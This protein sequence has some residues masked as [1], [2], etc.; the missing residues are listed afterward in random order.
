MLSTIEK[1]PTPY[2]VNETAAIWKITALWA[3]SE[4]A[5]GGVLHAF[6]V[7]FRG[8]FIGGAAAILISLIAF[9]SK[10]KG[11]ILRSTIIVIIIKGIASPYTP[12]TAY[13][14]VF[15]QGIIAEAL[16]F[17]RK[18]FKSS[19][20]VLGILV[21]LFSSTQK[22]IILTVLFGNT[23]W[24]SI[25]KFGNT[26]L[27]EFITTINSTDINFSYLIVGSYL[28]V[29]IILGMIIGTFAGKFPY[30]ILKIINHE[31]PDIDSFY[32][33]INNNVN[34][35]NKRHRHWWQ[36]SSG[37]ILTVF[38]IVIL[39]MS[40]LH[41]EWGSNKTIEVIIMVFRAVCIMGIWFFILAP[42]ILKIL[43]KYLKKKQNLYSKEISRIVDNFPHFKKLVFHCW[44]NSSKEKGYQKIKSFA[45]QLVTFLLL[46]DFNRL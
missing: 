17:N 33:S 27:S 11:I 36:K 39:I 42:L 44:K 22:L 29:H 8:V 19:A 3:F 26:I 10:E 43:R 34:T 37:I 24:D 21:L 32:D 38:I 2:Q 5:L 9:F 12:L 46:L 7:P 16:F 41:P 31:K 13:L 25:N 15:L 23:F 40:Y 30:K 20:F 28:G 14:A 45:T 4:A 6:R 35:N 18:I 1:Y